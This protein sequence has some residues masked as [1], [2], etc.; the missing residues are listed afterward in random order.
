MSLDPVTII[1]ITIISSLL[2]GISLLV[3]S[4]GYLGQIQGITKWA[5][6]TLLQ[7]LGWITLA[8]LRGLIPDIISIV[9]GNALILLS[10]AR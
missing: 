3:V 1:S 7:C 5:F 6:A 8:A 9:L 2:M 10:L 4:R